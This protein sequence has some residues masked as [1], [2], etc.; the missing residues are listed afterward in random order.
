MERKCRYV[1]LTAQPLVLALTQVRFTRLRQLA[2]YVPDIQEAYRR[3]GF[4]I[5]RAGKLQQVEL[6]QGGGPPRFSQQDRWEYRNRDE[7]WSIL[8]TEDGFVLQASAYDR[9]EGFAETM[10]SALE[11]LFRVTEHAEYGLVERVGLRYI[12]L[13]Q[14]RAGESFRDYLN[15]GFHGASDAVF[16]QGSHRVFVESAGRTTLSFGSGTLILRVA[17]DDSGAALPP[18]L[19]A[20]APKHKSRSKPGELVTF[21]DMDHFTEGRYDANAES[22]TSM[23]YELHDQIIEAF[24]NEVATQHAMEVWK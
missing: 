7:T 18:D 17:Q 12:D 20:A 6:A 5:E 3:T 22:V 11:V 14:P 24:H 15:P 9:F 23:A 16:N 13:V 21:V 19:L 2:H 1:P 8:L 10:R 4:P